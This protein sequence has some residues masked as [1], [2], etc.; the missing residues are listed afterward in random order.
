MS[1]SFKYFTHY[2]PNVS[3]NSWREFVSLFL[4]LSSTNYGKYLRFL[5]IMD[6]TSIRPSII[7]CLF[8]RPISC[9]LYINSEELTVRTAVEDNFQCSHT[10]QH[11]LMYEDHVSS[12]CAPMLYKAYNIRISELL[13]RKKSI[14]RW[15]YW[16]M[17]RS[18]I[19]NGE[20]VLFW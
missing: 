13:N 16:P 2:M 14:E 5:H 4:K 12:T 9:N 8:F 20:L 10:Q 17:E 18:C 19:Y 11:P 15:I 1:T 7:Q 3:K 6:I